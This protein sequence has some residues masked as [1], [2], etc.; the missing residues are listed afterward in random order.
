MATIRCPHGYVTDWEYNQLAV[1]AHLLAE[2]ETEA[3]RLPRTCS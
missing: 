2:L 3:E 1:L